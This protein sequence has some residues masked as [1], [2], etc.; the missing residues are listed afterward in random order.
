MSKDRMEYAKK[1]VWEMLFD[2]IDENRHT[3]IIYNYIGKKKWEEQISD[4]VSDIDSLA[5][6]IL[7]DQ[8]QQEE[9]YEH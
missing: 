8:D 2:I 6:Y 7:E 4:I 5:A 1:L 9:R 3:S